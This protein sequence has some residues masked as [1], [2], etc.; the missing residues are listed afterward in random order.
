MNHSLSRLKKL[1]PGFNQRPQTTDDFWKLVK[2]EKIYV[3][4]WPLPDGG[5]G[6]YGVNKKYRRIYRYIVIDERLIDGDW[7]AT[8]FHEL[9]HHF[10]HVPK[11]NLEVYFSHSSGSKRKSR[12][13]RE[14][15]DFSLIM[16]LPK[17]LFLELA[18]T[19]FDEIFDFSRGELR[20]RRELIEY[21][22]E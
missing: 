4:F 18:A 9:I 6:F 1:I 11:S 5:N 10:L 22:G 16:R 19:P 3:D 8:A 15:D 17:P 14:A 12:E 2:R 13:D 20:R 21:Y 7:L